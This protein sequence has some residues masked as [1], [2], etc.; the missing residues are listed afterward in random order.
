MDFGFDCLILRLLVGLVLLFWCGL[1]GCGFLIC[2]W[3]CDCRLLS[4]CLRGCLATCG[5][6]VVFGVLGGLL[7]LTGCVLACRVGCVG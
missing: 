4:C 7:A 6:V 2:V 3:F 1:W 5:C